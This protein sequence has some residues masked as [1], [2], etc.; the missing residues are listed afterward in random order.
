MFRATIFRSSSVITLLLFR[1][2]AALRFRA[3][4]RRSS[5]VIFIPLSFFHRKLSKRFSLLRIYPL[6]PPAIHN[7]V[8]ALS[9][10]FLL[11]LFSLAF[12]FSSILPFFCAFCLTLF[13]S[14]LSL[15]F[16][17]F[18]CSALLYAFSFSKRHALTASWLIHVLLQLPLRH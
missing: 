6:P 4:L 7:S 17:S 9:L 10:L 13:F 5:S 12:P 1:G 3:T 11:L 14:L 18:L 2:S 8:E 16:L 15:F